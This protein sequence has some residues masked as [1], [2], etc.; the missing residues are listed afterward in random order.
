MMMMV[1]VVLRRHAPDAVQAHALQQP[2]QARQGD[3]PVFTI[4]KR[5]EKEKRNGGGNTFYFYVKINK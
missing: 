1:V 3:G 2:V 5:K 4:P